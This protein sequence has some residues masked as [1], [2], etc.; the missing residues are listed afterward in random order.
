MIRLIPSNGSI[1][2]NKCDVNINKLL[3]LGYWSKLTEV[4]NEKSLGDFSLI[5][6]K[7]YYLK[8]LKNQ[9]IERDNFHDLMNPKNVFLHL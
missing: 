6:K 4:G 3:K 7:S 2:I 8:H 1:V 9:R 5:N